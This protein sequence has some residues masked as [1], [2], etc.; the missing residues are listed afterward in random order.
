MPKG[1]NE[2]KICPQILYTSCLI[3]QTHTFVWEKAMYVQNSTDMLKD[4]CLFVCLL[5]GVQQYFR[6][7][8]ASVL[9]VEEARV[10]RENHRPVTS[11]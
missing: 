5:D 1:T 3:T 10:P 6:Y 4:V 9:L 7:I 8:V 2:T 11:H